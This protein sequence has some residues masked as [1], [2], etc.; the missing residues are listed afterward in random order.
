MIKNFTTQVSWKKT[1]AFWLQNSVHPDTIKVAK[2]S[3]LK[4]TTKY[5][6][7][8]CPVLVPHMTGDPFPARPVICRASELHAPMESPMLSVEAPAVAKPGS[9]RT[10]L[11]N[12]NLMRQMLALAGQIS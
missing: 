12:W 10:S 9:A 1:Q 4:T 8:C 11:V 6:S 3:D 5:Y 7:L 2:K